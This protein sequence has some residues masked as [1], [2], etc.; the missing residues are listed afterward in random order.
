MIEKN[1]LFDFKVETAIMDFIFIPLF[2]SLYF[3]YHFFHDAGFQLEMFTGRPVSVATAEALDIGKRVSAFYNGFIVFVLLTLAIAYLIKRIRPALASEDLNLLNSTSA[4]GLCL[5]LFQLVGAD[6]APSL[7]LIIAIQLVISLGIGLKQKWEFQH[8]D[9]VY[10]ILLIWIIALSFS[11]YFL[12]VQLFQLAGIKGSQSLPVFIFVF[13]SAL[14][15]YYFLVQRKEPF[16]EAIIS[17]NFIITSPLAYLPLLSIISSEIY[18]ILNQHEI[19]SPGIKIIYLSLLLLLIVWMAFKR[20]KINANTLPFESD[21]LKELTKKWFPVLSVGIA[22]LATYRPSVPIAVDWFENA[23]RI[24]PLQQ[25]FDFGKIPFLDTFSSHA[26]SDFGTGVLFSLLNG[27]NPLGGFVYQFLIP[28]LVTLIIYQFVFRITQNGF[29]ALF[30]ALFYPYSDFILPSYY[31]LI[32]L[33]A[34]ALLNIYKQQSVKSYTVFF[35]VL[36]LMIFWRIDLGS[37]NLIAGIGGLAI[38]CYAVPG[39]KPDYK[40]LLKGFGIVTLSTVLIFILTAIF[41]D[42]NI[43]MR[44]SDALGYMSS[45]Q[46]YGIKDLSVSKDFEYYSLYFILPVSVFVAASYAFIRLVRMKEGNRDIVYLSLSLIFLSIYFF[47]NFQRGLVRH[48]LAEQWDTALSSYGF[49]IL[50][51][52]VFFNERFRNNKS[53]SFFIFITIA[54]LLVINYKFSSPDLTRNNMYFV[55]KQQVQ[56]ALFVASSNTKTDRTPESTDVSTNYNELNHFLKENFSDSSTFLDFSNSP[57]LYYYLHRIT[58]N[59]FCQ[60]PHT[61]H[62]EKMQLSFL[63]GIKKFDIPVV[64]FSNI[65]YNF[66][67]YLDGIPNTLRHYRISEYIYEN[68]RPYAIL[69][70]HSVWVKKNSNVKELQSGKIADINSLSGLEIHGAILKDSITISGKPEEN[71]RIKN[72]LSSPMKL[73]EGMNYFLSLSIISA[74]QGTLSVVSSFAG[75]QGTETRK[76]DIKLQAG[77]SEPFIILEKKP[78]EEIVQSVELILPPNPEYIV[79]SIQIEEC[80]YLPDLYTKQA[81]EQS[82]KFIPYVWGTFDK[83]STS[84]NHGPQIKLLKEPY[85]LKSDSEIRFMIPSIANKESGSYVKLRVRG[86]NEKA[87]DVILNYGSKNK[88]SGGFVFS[89]IQGDHFT[90]Y[91]IR[92]SSQYNWSQSEVEWISLYSIGSDLNLELL[93]IEK[94]E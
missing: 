70:K 16:S 24:L 76:T 14:L 93:D 58:P 94:G 62:N 20:R 44:L 66:W 34:L 59:Y 85:T 41:Y 74:T 83:I 68:Y 72:I 13:S 89:I 60:I 30:T 64:V 15:I 18:M 56:Q 92:M 22:A 3:V 35:L 46:S 21:P 71:I 88:K 25:Y 57:M 6:I 42:G 5:L 33:T 11:L 73:N 29:I 49:F 90:D 27:A 86:S 8:A 38:L 48:T 77:M 37:A 2:L 36:V 32:P 52:T 12:Q 50:A 4:A 17:G 80:Q 75:P 47:A 84:T 9:N 53:I 7:H 28:V 63:E 81:L 43:F 19:H 10:S 78:G 82:I 23:N 40:K 61:A 69:N 45:F 1:K 79:K 55:A 87:S 26:F 51:A 31:N 39:F 91:K 67:D 54:S 65:P